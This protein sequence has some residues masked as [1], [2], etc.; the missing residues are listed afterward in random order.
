MSLVPA[1][2]LYDSLDVA[3]LEQKYQL[4]GDRPTLVAS[5]FCDIVAS[6]E[7]DGH[8]GTVASK[9]R[10]NSAKAAAADLGSQ[11]VVLLELAVGESWKEAHFQSEQQGERDVRERKGDG[12]ALK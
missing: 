11:P 9:G 6:D 10:V 12:L 5:P 1:E 8:D 2:H 3:A 7:L 4:Q